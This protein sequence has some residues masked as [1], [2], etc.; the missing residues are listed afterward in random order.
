[1]AIQRTRATSDLEKRLKVLNQQLY[2]KE[3]SATN[4]QK[5]T[6]H[7][8]SLKSNNAAILKTDSSIS[9]I[10]YL[11]HDL[12]KIAIFTALALGLQF[13]LFY[14]LQHNLVKLPI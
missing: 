6:T 11:K 2:G 1:M 5:T 4:N 7:K 9:D 8:M 3:R 10:T 12:T 14:A 13:S